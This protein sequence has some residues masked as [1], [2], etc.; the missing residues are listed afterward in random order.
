M[1]TYGTKAAQN[2]KHALHER[3]RGQLKS[4][5][6]TTARSRRT[7][8]T[9]PRCAAVRNPIVGRRRVTFILGGAV[10]DVLPAARPWHFSC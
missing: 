10:I 1:A 4:G 8:A 5:R 7:L 2:V 6:S 9:V 3:K